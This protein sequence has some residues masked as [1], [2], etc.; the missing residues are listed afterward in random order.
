M[1]FTSCLL[2]IGSTHKTDIQ[3]YFVWILDTISRQHNILPH[4]GLMLDIKCDIGTTAKRKGSLC[5]YHISTEGHS[6]SF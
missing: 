5:K 3:E 6:K 1:G 4:T 2:W